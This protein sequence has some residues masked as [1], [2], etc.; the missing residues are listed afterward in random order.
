MWFFNI[1]PFHPPQSIANEILMN[2]RS[3]KKYAGDLYLQDTI[4]VDGDGNEMHIEDKLADT[5]LGIEDEVE[6][7]IKIAVL[8]DKIKKV[9]KSRE[10]VVLE[11]RYGLAGFDE[12]TQR[13]IADMLGISRSYVSRIEK[14]ALK[15]LFKEIEL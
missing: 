2:I 3:S 13:E 12:L 4:G 1:I 5:C 15:K 10:R 7:K 6:L 9:L 14:K 11:L 8:Y